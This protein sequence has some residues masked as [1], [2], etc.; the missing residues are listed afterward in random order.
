MNSLVKLT[1]DYVQPVINYLLG[2]CSTFRSLVIKEE[3]VYLFFKV[4]GPH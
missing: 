2:E 4:F 3:D 1:S